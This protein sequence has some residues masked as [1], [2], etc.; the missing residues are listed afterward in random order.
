LPRGAGN[1]RADCYCGW[2]GCGRAAVAGEFWRT[3]FLGE[4]HS[5]LP[6]KARD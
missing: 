1:E 2:P 3:N 6:G 4:L 5:Q